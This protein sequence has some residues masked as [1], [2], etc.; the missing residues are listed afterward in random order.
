M[1]CINN[2]S[3]I[4]QIFLSIYFHKSDKI[5]IMVVRDTRSVLVYSS[6]QDHMC[7]I[8]SIR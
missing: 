2:G 3:R 8:I 4:L 7:Q 6:T 5:F 1:I